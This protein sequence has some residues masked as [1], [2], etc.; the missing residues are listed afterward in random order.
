M[1]INWFPGHM[2]KARKE[3]AEV[4]PQVDIIIEMLDARI[5]FSSENPLVPQLRGNTPCIKVLNKADLADPE[6]TAVWVAHFEQQS[7]VRAIPISQQHPEQIKALLKLCNEMLPERN[8]DIR[9]ARAMIMGI[10]NVG[11]S[12]LINTLAGRTIAKTGN[13]AGV[14]KAQQRI[15]LENNVILTDTPGFLW[16]KLSPPTCGYRLAV[17]GA[18]KDTVFEYADIALFAADYLLQVYPKEVMQR[19]DLTEQPEHDLA[20]LDA[21]GVRRG[22]MRKGGIVDLEKAGT[23][24]ITELRAGN[25]GPITLETPDMVSQEQIDAKAEEA[26][27][28]K[29]KA[30]RE[31][32][33]KR[34]AQRKYR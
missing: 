34:R 20:L 2:H 26:A 33:R 23:I 12:T 7:G 18:I 28:S 8:L 25:L 22:C 31:A 3:I 5:P 11:K 17:T 16:P 14:T 4:M 10:P 1:S 32:E 24:L 19:F 9:P 30:E 29:D 13:E 6:L 15:K 21:I 27:K